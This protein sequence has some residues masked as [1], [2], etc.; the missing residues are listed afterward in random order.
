[1]TQ[2]IREH[3]SSKHSEVWQN[4]V[5]VEKLKGWNKMKAPAGSSDTTSSSPSHLLESEVPKS[6]FTLEGFY[7][8]LAR[9]I[10]VDDQV[11][12]HLIY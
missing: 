2:T 6:T 9:W 7:E 11:S 4:I 10:V 12:Y 5:F 3:L 8:R 1:M